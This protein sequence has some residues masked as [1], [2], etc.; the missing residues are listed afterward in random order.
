M[1]KLGV[2]YLKHYKDT[3][4]QR[5]SEL[6]FTASKFDKS[7]KN[8]IGLAILNQIQG[9]IEESNEFMLQ[10][11]QILKNSPALKFELVPD[12]IFIWV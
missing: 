7:H 11:L 1:S 10:A 6:L 4:I 3:K 9:N 8:L 12:R 5:A 2:L